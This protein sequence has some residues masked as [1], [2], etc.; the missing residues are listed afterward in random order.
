MTAITSLTY[1][2][3]LIYPSGAANVLQS[4]NMA[5]AFADNNVTTFFFPGFRGNVADEVKKMEAGFALT[6]SPKLLMK[7]LSGSHKGIYGLNF[8]ARIA[9]RWLQSKSSDVFYARNIKEGLL[10]ARLKRKLRM[11]RPLFFEMHE[12]LA[13]QHASKNTG[14]AYIFETLERE[15]LDQVDGIISI[16]S[17]LSDDIKRKYAPTVPIMTAPMGFNQN[18]YRPVPPVDLSDQVTLAY[19]GSLYESKGIHNLVN[20][21]QFLPER[22]K[23]VVMGGKPLEELNRLM[24][25]A[26]KFPGRVEFTGHLT[27][28]DVA[29]KL[30]T[31]QMFVIP[32]VTSSEFFSPIKLYEAMGM[33]LPIV[34]TPVP[35]IANAVIHGRDAYVAAGTTPKDLAN[36]ILELAG[37]TE[38]VLAMQAH[39]R[40]H[41]DGFTWRHRAKLCLEF[42]DDV[43]ATTAGLRP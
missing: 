25:M 23:L 18:L 16:S 19:A 21:L 13:E 41:A 37:D 10:L 24:K 33:A 3:K 7:P 43:I 42:M 36:G 8:R 5:Y 32:Q 11:K 15:L 34:T 39:A 20:A 14:K 9:M 12:I 40:D 4:L 2:K 38:R 31:C 30:S 26:E 1:A 29:D 22:F 27:P 6:P 28:M 35:T 17:L